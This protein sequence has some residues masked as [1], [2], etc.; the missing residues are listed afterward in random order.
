MHQKSTKNK[1]IDKRKTLFV[2]ENKT[3]EKPLLLLF[4][5]FKK[6]LVMVV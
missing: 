2:P 3:P 5:T 1:A 6:M 4:C